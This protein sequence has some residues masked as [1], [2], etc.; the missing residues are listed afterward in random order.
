[1]GQRSQLRPCNVGVDALHANMHAEAAIDASH[2]ALVR[3]YRVDMATGP[4]TISLKSVHHS[5]QHT[6]DDEMKVISVQLAA[7]EGNS[8]EAIAEAAGAP[9]EVVQQTWPLIWALRGVGH[10]LSAIGRR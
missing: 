9:V 10:M 4:K 3:I 2:C 6:P 7:R 8:P 5:W 1:M